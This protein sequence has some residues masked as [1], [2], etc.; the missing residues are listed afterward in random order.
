MNLKWNPELFTIR[1]SAGDSAAAQ[2][3]V[4]PRRPLVSTIAVA[5]YPADPVK[6]IGELTG[7]LATADADTEGR[8][9]GDDCNIFIVPH[10]G[11]AYSGLCAAYAYKRMRSR[12]FRRVILLAPSHRVW[13]DNRIMLPESDAVSTPLG[14]IG[15]DPALVRALRTLSFTGMS[16][17]V[18]RDEHSTQIQYPFLQTVLEEGFT[19]LPVI[20]GKLRQDAASG[21]GALLLSLM[22]PET[23]LIVSSDFTH[24]GTRFGYAPFQSDFQNNVRLVDLEA[25]QHIQN[26]D[27]G[28]FHRFVERN[29]C[30]IC[31]SEPI[32][33]MLTMNTPVFETTLFRYCNS[34]SASGERDF[35]CYLA[36]G[37]R[38]PV[39][40]TSY[41]LTDSDK[42]LLLDF[43]RR[44]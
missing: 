29:H 24:Y 26:H 10:A 11:Y 43:A 15:I 14:T 7:Y 19:I 28:A 2:T 40:E 13:L 9:A 38:V 37:I 20:V 34:A 35:V 16:D 31:G 23:L 42:T 30:T 18:H 8:T 22:T 4:P 17:N 27:A 25:Y 44:A 3:G 6:L 36:C 39:A 32:R 21:L 5:W 1:V 12:G 41:D 33:A